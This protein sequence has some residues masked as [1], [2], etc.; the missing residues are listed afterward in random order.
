MN[1]LAQE[2]IQ[3][4]S[5]LTGISSLES[6]RKEVEIVTN[7]QTF[8]LLRIAVFAPFNHGKS[9]LL[10][11]LLGSRTLPISLLPTTGTAISIRNGGK[12][13]TRIELKNGETIYC[14]GTDI[15]QEYTV[16]DGNRSM[17]SDV[18]SAMVF[19]PNSLLAKGVELVDLPG[20]SD[21]ETQDELVYNQLLRADLV[22][23]LLDARKLLTMTEVDKL[24]EWLLKRGITTAV[25]ILNFVNLIEDE[26]SRQ[27]IAQQARFIATEFRSNLP[28]N[29]SNLYRVDVLPALRAKVKGDNALAIESGIVNF[30]NSLNT[31]TDLL[32]SKI[33]QVRLPRLQVIG[34]SLKQS[35]QREL[36]MICQEMRAIDSQRKAQID[37]LVEEANRMQS[38]FVARIKSVKNWLSKEDFITRYS[39]PCLQALSKEE[40]KEFVISLLNTCGEYFEPIERLLNEGS[41]KFNNTLSDFP[42][43]T[44]PD[45]PEIT[46][47]NRPP[48]L[49]QNNGSG[50][51]TFLGVV[52]GFIL[53]GPVGAAVGATG[54]RALAEKAAKQKKEQLQSEYNSQVLTVCQKS[55][56]E[57]LESFRQ[58]ILIL[59][60]EYQDSA[61]VLD[62][63][64]PS[65]SLMVLEKRKTLNL[66]KSSL[67]ALSI[68]L[69]NYL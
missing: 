25:F 32:L 12:L 7:H 21:M 60:E 23:C 66:L 39:D 59:I 10:N 35:L 22:I 5:Q 43:L 46:L 20:T 27:T 44:L 41:E 62:Y 36:N 31:I 24:Q 28:D 67:Q 26:E 52:G 29:I 61:E 63:E 13:K 18:V 19:C 65:E 57:Y 14:D 48:E 30:E 51:A 50:A 55:V 16:L 15:L 37:C 34:Q 56:R 53:G 6:L 40:L 1:T 47:P 9:T 49:D 45:F 68:E 17:R 38:I 54:A 3:I 58:A 64:P 42:T 2:I 69:K 4:N 11:A 33:T 8:P